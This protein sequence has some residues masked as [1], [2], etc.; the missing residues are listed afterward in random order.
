M[1]SILFRLELIIA[2]VVVLFAMTWFGLSPARDALPVKADA[3]T[4]VNTVQVLAFGGVTQ[5]Q[6]GAGVLSQAYGQADC[7]ARHTESIAS[8]VAQT[9]TFSLSH[10]PDTTHLVSLLSFTAQTTDA[11]EFTRTL[12]YGNYLVG[13]VT[14][15]D[16][17]RPI[18]GSIVCV[19]KNV[20]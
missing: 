4:S 17:T 13:S 20:Q 18:T 16:N 19:F 12:L 1:K 9:V 11:I 3:V 8:G 10:G 2:I 15:G 5:T 7:Y 6:T 14:I